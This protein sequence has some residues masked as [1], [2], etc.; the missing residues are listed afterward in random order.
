M[1]SRSNHMRELVADTAVVPVMVLDDV[2]VSVPLVNALIEGGLQIFEVTLRT[3][4]ALPSIAALSKAFPAALV[5]AGTVLNADDARRAHQA[6]AKFIVSP[7]YAPA[8]GE[9]C[10]E[11]GLPLLPGVATASEVMAALHDGYDFLK[12]FPAEAAG[13]TP[14]LRAWAGPFADVC[15]CPTGGITLANAPGYLALPNVCCVGGSWL[16]P[17]ELVQRRDWESLRTLAGEAS[18]LQKQPD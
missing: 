17:R 13:G 6:G 2:T 3:S 14:L 7:G 15:F 11:L 8:L 5:G 1:T 9:A 10:A 16:T 18:R 12:F 4:A